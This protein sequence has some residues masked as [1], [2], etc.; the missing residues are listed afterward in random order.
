MLLRNMVA[1]PSLGSTVDEDQAD[2]EVVWICMTNE[3]AQGT[4][5]VG[6]ASG[7]ADSICALDAPVHLPQ[8]FV[9][10]RDSA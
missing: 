5:N 2:E 9:A 4:A 1:E 6:G 3:E 7:S 8:R 10:G